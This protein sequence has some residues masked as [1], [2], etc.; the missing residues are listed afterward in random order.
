MAAPHEDE[1]SDDF[2]EP[3][4]VLSVVDDDGDMTMGDDDDGEDIMDE[5]NGDD[6]AE[7]DE[8]HVVYEDTS[9]SHFGAHEGSVFAIAAH[10]TQPLAVSGGE[11]DLGYIWNLEDGEMIVKL[12]GHSDSVTSVGWSCDGELVSTGG[13]DGK[14]RIWRRVKRVAAEDWKTWEFLTELTGPDEVMWLKW[15]PRGS[16][17]LAGS[18]DSTVWLW[19][20]PSGNTMQVL[21]SHAGPVNAGCFTPDGKKVL[22]GS[23]TLLLTTPTSDAPLLKLSPADGRFALEGG[24]TA[25]AVN[26]STA[27]AVVGGADGS[28]R[29]VSL[30]KGDVVGR[31]EGHREGESIEGATWMEYAGTEVAVT[32]GTDGKVCVWD[33]STMRL[34]ITLEH[35]DAVTS[36]HPHPLPSSYLLTTSSADKTLRTWDVRTGAV[37]REH[38]GHHGPVLGASLG[39]IDGRVVVVSAGDDG[40]C[41]AF[42]T[43]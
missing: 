18:N 5:I 28:V 16:V 2:I 13:M 35:Q 1:A 31:L 20:L 42:T 30:G 29:V 26:A 14:V 33:M 15:H 37:V 25:L 8:D 12:T 6:I 38:K 10:P 17:L 27:L 34:R 32:G 7:G 36:I 19:Q 24:I 3:S 39:V 11:D 41:L 4:E 22:T 40:A 43:E 9:F 21:A 23:D